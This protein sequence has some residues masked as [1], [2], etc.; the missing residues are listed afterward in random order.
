MHTFVRLA[1][2]LGLS[3][4]AEGVETE[5]QRQHLTAV[6][7]GNVQGYLFGKPP[8]SAD[9]LSLLAGVSTAKTVAAA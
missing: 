6:G 3:V 8:S 5:S 9:I 2:A 4:I 1:R 7:C